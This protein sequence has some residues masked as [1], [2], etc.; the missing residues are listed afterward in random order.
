MNSSESIETLY[1]IILELKGPREAKRF[2]SDVLF[3]VI[4]DLQEEGKE[5]S[6]FAIDQK[7]AQIATDFKQVADKSKDVA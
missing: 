4:D 7:L 2:T 1:R 6:A 5:I 3:G